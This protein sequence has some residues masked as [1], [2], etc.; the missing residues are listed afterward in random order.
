[1]VGELDDLDQ[2]A[3]R[4]EAAEDHPRLVH[5]L[6]VLVVELKAVAMPLVHD[7]FAVGPERVRARQQ[8]ARV[9]TEAHGAAHLVHVALLGHEVDDRRRREGGELGRVGVGSVEL[10]ASEVDD[11]ALH[12][13]AQAEIRDAVVACIARGL[14]LALDPAI[15]ESAGHDDPRHAFERRGVAGVEL[16]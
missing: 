4:R 5:D 14:D 10:L 2:P 6:A 9:K 12:A 13:E 3:V 7:L 16:F 11:R 1:V 15:A 8:L